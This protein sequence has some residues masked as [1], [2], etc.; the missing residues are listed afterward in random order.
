MKRF[1][2]IV[3]ALTVASSPDAGVAATTTVAAVQKKPAVSAQ[4]P[5]LTAAQKEAA[6]LAA[7]RELAPADEYFGPL[8]LSIIGIRN[9]IRDVGLR[10]DYNHEIGPQ[11]YNSAQMAEKSIRDWEKK[12]PHD[13]Q[14]PRAVFYLQRLYTKL[15]TQPSR[16]R[17][18]VVALWMFSDFAKSPQSR[19]LKKT[20]A[21]EHLAA[22]PPP[23]PATPAPGSYASDFGP[24]Y[25]SDFTA[26]NPPQA[27]PAPN[28]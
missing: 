24:K 21:V 7:V 5:H 9:T 17:A 13:D 28:R 10:Y 23:G 27:S 16:D 20:V 4:R 2:G 11:S 1:I 15:L 6:R 19:Q 25:P 22:I 26:Q 14:L 3:A 18:H 12:Y 8:K